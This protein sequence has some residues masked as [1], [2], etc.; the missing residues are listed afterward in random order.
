M[1]L[2]QF[3]ACPQTLV[4]SGGKKTG[5]MLFFF[6]YNRYQ[7]LLSLKYLNRPCTKCYLLDSNK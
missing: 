6:S 3:G 5:Q 4:N 1:N 2:G 7:S